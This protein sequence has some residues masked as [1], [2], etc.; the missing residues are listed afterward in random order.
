LNVS[1]SRAHKIES[2]LAMIV[3]ALGALYNNASSPNASPGLYVFKNLGPSSF[4]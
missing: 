1:L 4:F 2:V 3:A